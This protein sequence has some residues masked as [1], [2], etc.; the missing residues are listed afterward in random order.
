[1]L[2]TVRSQNL[3]SLVPVVCIG[4]VDATD[5]LGAFH[6]G[7]DGVL[8]LGCAD[9][10]CHFQDGNQEARKKM[11]LLHKILESFG[12]AKERLE[13]VTAIDA[14]AERL[15]GIIN[16]FTDRLKGLQPLKR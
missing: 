1:M 2:P 7:A 9:G 14:Q 15:P 12:I 6:K 11:Y 8:L 10:D 4:K 16:S 3:K 13:V 5:I